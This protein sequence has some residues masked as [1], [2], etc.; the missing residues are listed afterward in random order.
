M[1]SVSTTALGQRGSLRWHKR[2]Y[3]MRGYLPIHTATTQNGSNGVLISRPP[4]GTSELPEK[5][6]FLL[7]LVLSTDCAANNMIFRLVALLCKLSSLLAGEDS[8]SA[9]GRTHIQ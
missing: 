8:P 3:D 7:I 6:I 1:Q 2:H 9:G 5:T 4:V